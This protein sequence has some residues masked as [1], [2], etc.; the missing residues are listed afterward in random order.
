MNIGFIG[1]GEVG[2]EMSKGFQSYDNGQTIYVYDP[3]HESE[4]TRQRAKEANVNLVDDPIKVVQNKLDILF[5]AVPAL[6]AH[7]AWSSIGKYLN[8]KT[9]CVDLTTASSKMKQ[10]ISK[11]MPIRNGIIDGA[12]MGPLK[13]NQQKVPMLISGAGA[14]GFEKWGKSFDMNLTCISENVGDATNIKFIR[15]IFTKGL[16]TLLHEVMEIAD[17]LELDDIIL[18][19]ITS[20]IDNEPFEVILNRLITSNVLHSER[21]VQE[22]DNVMEFLIENKVVPQMT[23]ATR[24]KLVEITNS[25]IK[26]KFAGREPQ[27][28]KEVMRT[29]RHK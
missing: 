15:S 13:G 4:A 16:S 29:L 9:L 6:Y 3:L 26:E 1:F 12:I 17:S 20:T 27:H 18:A 5:V 19:S 28:W 10:Q 8:V 11:E 23:Q 7:D 25:N 21:R 24:N 2:Y 14:L 22:M